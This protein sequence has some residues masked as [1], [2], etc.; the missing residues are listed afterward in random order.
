M[1]PY[2]H[3]P[4]PFGF[5]AY[6]TIKTAKI[7][8]VAG[9]PVGKFTAEIQEILNTLISV[10]KLKPAE[11]EKR[12]AENLDRYQDEAPPQEVVT[13]REAPLDQHTSSLPS[14]AA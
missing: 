13:S 12:I 4:N 10:S 9:K 2:S 8:K 6:Y 14:T 5:D 11:A 1:S 3:R 7:K